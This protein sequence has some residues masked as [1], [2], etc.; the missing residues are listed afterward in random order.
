MATHVAHHSSSDILPNSFPP[1]RPTPKD[2]GMVSEYEAHIVMHKTIPFTRGVE[3]GVPFEK[4][5]EYPIPQRPQP[6]SSG[7][8]ITDLFDLD[9]ALCVTPEKQR[10]PFIHTQQLKGSGGDSSDKLKSSQKVRFDQTVEVKQMSPETPMDIVKPVDSSSHKLVQQNVQCAYHSVDQKSKLPSGVRSNMDSPL[11]INAT[12][13][14][15]ADTFFGDESSY[16]GDPISVIASDLSRLRTTGSDYSLSEGYLSDSSDKEVAS[17][18]NFAEA[19]S[20]LARPEFNSVLMIS[21]EKRHLEDL[22]PDLIQAAHK[23]LRES[24]KDKAK[25]EEKVRA[26]YMMHCDIPFACI[27]Y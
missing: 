22:Q 15:E 12:S 8:L 17:I 10:K 1:P 19:E 24:E 16:N 3:G 26:L 14:C 4:D 11:T 23:K 25:I 6:T 13:S 5:E 18:L 2:H 20:V 27:L 21:E 7:S 9:P